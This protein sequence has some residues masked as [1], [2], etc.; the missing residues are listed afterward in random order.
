MGTLLA[1]PFCQRNHPRMRLAQL[2]LFCG[3][4]ATTSRGGDVGRFAGLQAPSHANQVERGLNAWSRA[5][6]A[7]SKEKTLASLIG[8]ISRSRKRPFQLRRTVGY[9]KSARARSHRLAHQ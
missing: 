8:L 6:R 3:L 4:S 1:T 7:V 5:R 9:A 2:R